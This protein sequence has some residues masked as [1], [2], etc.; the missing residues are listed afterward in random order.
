MKLPQIH[1]NFMKILQESS[2]S[3]IKDTNVG[4][5]KKKDKVANNT[6]VGKDRE[7]AI[8]YQCLPDWEMVKIYNSPFLIDF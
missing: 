7:K 8:C 5:T 6:N 3:S 4:E 1:E 2:S